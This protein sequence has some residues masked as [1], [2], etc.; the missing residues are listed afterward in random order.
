MLPFSLLPVRQRGRA[1]EGKRKK[2][3]GKREK[4]KGKREKGRDPPLLTEG[5]F[6]SPITITAS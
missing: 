5:V 2:G 1:V 6:L 4:E 3:K